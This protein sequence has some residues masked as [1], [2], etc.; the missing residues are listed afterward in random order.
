MQCKKVYCTDK[1]LHN[2]K[3]RSIESLLNCNT[4]SWNSK[5]D[6]FVIFGAEIAVIF[7]SLAWN[8]NT[9]FLHFQVTRES[10]HKQMCSTITNSPWMRWKPAV[11]TQRL[12]SFSVHEA[13]W[14]KTCKIV[15]NEWMK[16][17]Q[18]RQY[19]L[20]ITAGKIILHYFVKL[21]GVFPILY[22][23]VNRPG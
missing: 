4:A 12:K 14:R 5:G 8:S 15:I 3:T 7:L 6:I 22:F 16:Y 21:A 20:Q 9:L 2:T 23:C 13:P 1:I 17:T 10:L 19:C 18:S 11:Q